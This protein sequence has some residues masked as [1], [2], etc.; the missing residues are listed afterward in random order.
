MARVAV[1]LIRLG[2]HDSLSSPV[3][4]CYTRAAVI[5]TLFMGRVLR[6]IQNLSCVISHM[7]VD[8]FASVAV[9]ESSLDVIS[10]CQN[11]EH[12]LKRCPQSL[13]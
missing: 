8:V 7:L 5:Y 11:M 3:S 1:R 4:S 2:S 10:Q 12:L 6:S 13:N 9:L